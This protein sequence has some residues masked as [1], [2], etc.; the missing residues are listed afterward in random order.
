[1]FTRG[2]LINLLQHLAL[3]VLATFFGALSAAGLNW[4][5][6][7]TVHAALITAGAAGIGVVQGA[8]A[9]L[10]SPP[11]STTAFLPAAA[12]QR[13]VYAARSTVKDQPALPAP[14]TRDEFVAGLRE[15]LAEARQFPVQPP[16]AA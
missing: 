12:V 14:L 1:M 2:W 3:V 16:P 8:L 5:N 9:A 10:L 4:L 13:V 7:S 15:V 11:A 6:L